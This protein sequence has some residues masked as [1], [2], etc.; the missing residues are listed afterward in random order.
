MLQHFWTWIG[1][2]PHW[3]FLALFTQ[4]RT[5]TCTAAGLQIYSPKTFPNT[6]THTCKHQ[7]PRHPHGKDTS[8]TLLQCAGH[9]TQQLE[10]RLQPS[11]G[12]KPSSSWAELL[13]PPP[14]KRAKPREVPLRGQELAKGHKHTCFCSYCPSLIHSVFLSSSRFHILSLR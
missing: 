11:G 1:P 14:V 6:H 10:E 9:F 2:L 13:Q 8:T 7:C 12:I 5:S 4:T 3:P